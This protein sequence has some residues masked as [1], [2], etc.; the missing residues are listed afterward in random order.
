MYDE[1]ADRRRK[2]TEKRNA[3]RLTQRSELLRSLL[4]TLRHGKSDQVDRVLRVVRYHPSLKDIATTILQAR[5]EVN[6]VD[7]TQSLSLDELDDVSFEILSTLTPPRF[8]PQQRAL[9][10]Q[11]LCCDSPFS[12]S[13]DRWTTVADKK[14]VTHLISTYLT[15]EQPFMRI[16][17]E[18]AFLE[19]MA[20]GTSEFCSSF[21]VNAICAFAACVSWR[22]SRSPLAN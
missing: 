14:I 20:A 13:G 21:L 8:E 22:L 3:D 10:L 18:D 19:D 9:S 6:D 17:D 4:E 5:Q 1:S 15:W 12:V 16:L 7:S 2:I 11:E